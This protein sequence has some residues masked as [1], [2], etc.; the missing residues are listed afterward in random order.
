MWTPIAFGA[1]DIIS[2]PF[3]CYAADLQYKTK[4]VWILERFG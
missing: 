1:P 4:K 2:K 3:E